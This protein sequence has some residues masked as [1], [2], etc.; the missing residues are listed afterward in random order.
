MARVKT[1][2]RALIRPLQRLFPLEIEADMVNLLEEIG[3][4][5]ENKKPDDKDGEK[6]SVIEKKG[7]T[8]IRGDENMMDS[9]PVITRFGRTVKI[10]KSS[11]IH[12]FCNSIAK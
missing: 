3:K 4:K 7:V 11:E 9:T 1:E 5:R 6:N 8:P 2:Y 12:R 10:P